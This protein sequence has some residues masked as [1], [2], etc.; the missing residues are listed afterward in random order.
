[1][2]FKYLKINMSS[3]SYKVCD[4][5]ASHPIDFEWL[6]NNPGNLF[7][8]DINVREREM[9][10]RNERNASCEQN[11]WPAEDCGASS[12]RLRA[13]GD[14][15]THTQTITN[16]EIID[17]A[18]GNDCNLTCS[19]CCKVYSSAWQRDLSV[20][21]NY[22]IYNQSDSRYKI[23][24]QDQILSKISQNELHDSSRYQSLI[25]EVKLRGS[26]LKQ[27]I[28]TGGE[29]LLENRLYDML[30][31]LDLNPD[32]KITLFT[33]MGVNTA[34]FQRVISQ[35]ANIKNLNVIVS[36]ENVGD[37]LEF[38]RYGVKWSE[39]QDK[40][41][42]LDQHVNWSFNCVISNLTIF[43]FVDFYNFFKNRQMKLTFSHQPSMM[44]PFVLD[45]ASKAYVL[46]QIKTVD[47]S[48]KNQIEKNIAP[49]PTESQ[50][51]GI[52]DFLTTFVARRPDLDLKIFPKTFLQWL[53]STY[54]V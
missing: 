18:I 22:E 38:N 35:L 28:V 9:M 5:A 37:F 43:G 34:R 23:T 24:T 40:I 33:G 42:I 16:P 44:N 10:L 31:T 39:F 41:Q 6:K 26:T 32:C 3:Y 36:A 53:D 21:G 54:V 45:P 14:I 25:D 11:C 12:P 1:M 27:L 30:S 13:K 52:R 19:Y 4:A 20:N 48:Y 29:P 8:T 51:K 17:I 49:D 7:N 15:V 2:K 47:S 50:R 46:E